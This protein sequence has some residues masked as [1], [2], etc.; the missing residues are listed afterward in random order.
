MFALPLQVIDNFL[1]QFNVGQAL[2][3]VF[4]LATLGVLPLKSRKLLGLHVLT[5]GLIFLLTPDSL[6]PVEYKFFGVALLFV[7][8]FL[9]ITGRR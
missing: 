3:F 4:V 2:L 5:F 7:G 6:Q 8:P 1:L 9:L